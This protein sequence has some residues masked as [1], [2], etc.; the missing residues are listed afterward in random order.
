[1]RPYQYEVHSGQLKARLFHSTEHCGPL[2][3]TLFH[4]ANSFA[5]LKAKLKPTSKFQS[6]PMF[7]LNLD[8][9]LLLRS[10]RQLCT[11][12][13]L[14]VLSMKKYDIWQILINSVHNTHDH[15]EFSKN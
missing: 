11:N 5:P 14:L 15:L 2:K 6:F 9:E 12:Y 13:Q 4:S 1:M 7:L 8:Y 10:L 3:A